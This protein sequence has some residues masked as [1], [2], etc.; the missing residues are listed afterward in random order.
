MKIDA[1]FYALPVAAAIIV[2][3]WILLLIIAL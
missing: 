3:V 1:Q 2:W